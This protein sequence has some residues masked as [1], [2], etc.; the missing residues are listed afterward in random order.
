MF[1]LQVS[2]WDVAIVGDFLDEIGLHA[3]KEIFRR[4]RLRCAPLCALL[5]LFP[6]L[7]SMV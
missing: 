4:V 6:F 2:S 5:S 3:Y 1:C 7:C